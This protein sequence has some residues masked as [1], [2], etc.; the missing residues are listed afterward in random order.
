MCRLKSSRNGKEN[1]MRSRQLLLSTVG[2]AVVAGLAACG[3]G[4]G[5]APP[6]TVAT[7]D[8]TAANRDVVSHA[9][10]AGILG[11]SVTDTIP[12]TSNSAAAGREQPQAVGIAQRSGWSGR[13]MTALLP[14]LRENAQAVIGPVVQACAISGSTSSSLDDRDGN[15]VPSV[16]EV[17]TIAFNNCKVTPDETLTGTASAAI[18]AVGTTSMSMRLTASQMSDVTTSHSVTLDGTML[19]DYSK[20]GASTET[21][22][23]TAD[24]PVVVTVSTHVGFTDTVTLLSGF[25][26]QESFDAS[27]APPAGSTASTPGRTVNT[28]KGSLRSGLAGGVVEVATLAGAAL[29]KYSADDY[30]RSGTVQVKGKNSMLQITAL[31]AAEVRLDLDADSNG[32]F[33]STSTV[34]WDWLL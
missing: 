17:L 27:V 14:P 13:L 4:G 8:I 22:K 7:I 15:G 10:A 23:V 29:T 34:A 3:G 9:T 21:A 20:T 11:L 24:G 12:V 16:G 19:F 6:A 26:V 28:V 18:T 32:S 5:D 31:S 1:T 25:V 30:P 2:F 33:E